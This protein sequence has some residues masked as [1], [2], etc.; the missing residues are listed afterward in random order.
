[1]DVAMLPDAAQ[2]SATAQAKE[3]HAGA[4]RVYDAAAGALG[5]SL[6]WEYFDIDLVPCAYKTRSDWKDGWPGRFKVN[7]PASQRWPAHTHKQAYTDAPPRSI[8]IA[9]HHLALPR[10][11]GCS[12][13]PY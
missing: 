13:V 10:A 7:L 11:G 6:C 5:D 1:M 12:R 4:M 8:S 3:L 2:G 9:Q